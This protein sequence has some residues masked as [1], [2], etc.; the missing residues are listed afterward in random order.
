MPTYGKAYEVNGAVAARDTGASGTLYTCP[1]A[2]FAILNLY[3]GNAAGPTI[4]VGAKEVS[5][6]SGPGTF[7]TT[8]IYVGPGQSVAFTGNSGSNVIAVSGVEFTNA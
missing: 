8:Q 2:S 1:A 5:V 4:T 7:G 6:G 3:V